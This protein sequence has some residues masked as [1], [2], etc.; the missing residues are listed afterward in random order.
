MA[1]LIF[2]ISV[3]A[4][5]YTYIGYPAAVYLLARL[6]GKRVAK[7]GATPR[8]SVV[9]ACHNEA[10]NIQSRIS[11]LLESD[12]PAE[13]LEIIVVSD[14]STD[15]TA[16]L[17][18]LAQSPRVRALHYR[19]R[20]GKAAALNL[21]VENASGEVIVFAD[22]RQRFEPRAIRELVANM[23]D[24]R[25]GAVSGELL[26]D[27]PAG[28][29]VGEGV[30]LYWKYEKW[31]RKNESRFNSVIGATGAIYAIRRELWKPLPL[32][33]I[34]DDV[35][36]PM[37]IALRGR[38]VVFEEKARAYDR[39]SAC[40]G[41]E[42][43]RKVRTLT[44]NYQLCQLMP[45][46]LLPWGA[47]AFQFYSHKILR[48]AAPVFLLLLLASS[49][50]AVAS[51][52]LDLVYQ[53]ALALQAAFYASVLAGACLLRRNRKVRLLSFAYVFSVMNAAALVGLFYFITGKRDIWVRGQ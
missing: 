27:A 4:I 45:R 34:L 3:V 40:A 1:K 33:T 36:T 50:L 2:W 28:S 12:Y 30:G 16:D 17:A 31:I 44:G 8:V 43:A 29:S 5:F 35:Y 32:S 38:R 26:L 46:L 37:H 15:R 10:R 24:P 53:A 47:L 7:S 20:S 6:R 18:R 19:E 42:F 22:A 49:A 39:A 9:V 51:D 21:G 23:S 48:L 13:L 11:N 14:G 41:G 25:V 52:P